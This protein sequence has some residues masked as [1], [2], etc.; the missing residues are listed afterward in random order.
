MRDQNEIVFLGTKDKHCPIY[1][2]YIY[3]FNPN[4]L[5]IPE[6]SL[7]NQLE[8]QKVLMVEMFFGAKPIEINKK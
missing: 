2:D 6:W 4:K 7:A 3:I 8:Q 5:C 1:K